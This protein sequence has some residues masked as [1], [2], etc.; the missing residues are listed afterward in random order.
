MIASP[1]RRQARPDVFGWLP[2]LLHWSL[3]VVVL[4]AFATAFLAH[5]PAVRRPI[6]IGWHNAIGLTAGALTLALVLWR[7]YGH[8]P[9]PLP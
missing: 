9:L 5:L 6:V 8:A 1:Q 2:R 4:A 7:S 3:A